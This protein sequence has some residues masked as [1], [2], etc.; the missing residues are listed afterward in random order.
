MQLHFEPVAQSLSGQREVA[1]E[2][3]GADRGPDCVLYQSP[4]VCTALP[5]GMLQMGGVAL[6]FK[7]QVPP[8]PALYRLEQLAYYFLIS[9]NVTQQT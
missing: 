4:Y 7:L 9:P 6:F 1:I 2:R 8:T 3:G 5:I